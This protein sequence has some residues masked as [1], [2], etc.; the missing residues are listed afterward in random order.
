MELSELPYREAPRH[1]ACFIYPKTKIPECPGYRE[2]WGACK[3]LRQHSGF[4]FLEDAMLKIQEQSEKAV[5]EALALIKAVGDVLT[6]VNHSGAPD[7]M[8]ETLTSLGNLFIDKAG[9]ISRGIGLE[10]E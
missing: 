4:F 2:V 1:G 3:A 10:L 8:P 7:L 5:Y 9:E 6:F